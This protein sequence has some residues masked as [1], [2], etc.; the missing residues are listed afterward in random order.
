ME[1]YQKL[2]DLGSGG[3]ASAALVRCLKT[4]RQF[5][6]KQIPLQ[7][8]SDRGR[9]QALQEIACLEQCCTDEHPFICQVRYFV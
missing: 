9:R 4:Q 1:S 3:F 5:V 7:G 6:M 2:K 8:L